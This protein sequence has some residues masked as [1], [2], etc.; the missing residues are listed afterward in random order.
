MTSLTNYK[1]VPSNVTKWSVLFSSDPYHINGQVRGIYQIIIG[2]TTEIT[3]IYPN[4]GKS[5]A[6]STDCGRFFLV[7]MSIKIGG[8]LS[9]ITVISEKNRNNNPHVYMEWWNIYIQTLGGFQMSQDLRTKRKAQLNTPDRTRHLSFLGITLINNHFRRGIIISLLL[10]ILQKPRKRFQFIIKQLIV[11]CRHF[12]NKLPTLI[13]YSNS[14]CIIWNC[15]HLR[16]NPPDGSRCI[17]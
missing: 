5:T 13:S 3:S 7:I 10:Y 14:F 17:P 12:L 6:E 15:L 11:D 8:Y 9:Q 2:W 16:R 4:R 1:S